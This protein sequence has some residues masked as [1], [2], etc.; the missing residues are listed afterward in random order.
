MAQTPENQDFNPRNHMMKVKG[1]DYLPVSAR[2]IWFRQDFPSADIQ[3]ELVKLDDVAG[4]VF[5]CRIIIPDGG[6]ATGWGSCRPQDFPDGFIEKAETKARGRA[7]AALGYGT[8]E[9]EGDGDMADGPVNRQ[10]GYQGQQ[11]RRQGNWSN[12]PQGG[13][14]Q[15]GY[16]QQAQQGGNTAFLA[17]AP[18]KS[19]I[20]RLAA[21]MQM[22]P[23]ELNALIQ[24]HTGVA[25]VDMNKRQASSMIDLLEARRPQGSNQPQTAPF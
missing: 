20:Q 7:L 22:Q 2:L 18:Q 23:D 21:E 14:P 16:Q 8:P 24:Q 12:G 17:T 3:A 19:R 11:P 13:P 9:D 5:M 6:A 15:G 1:G 25:F 10:D 4:A